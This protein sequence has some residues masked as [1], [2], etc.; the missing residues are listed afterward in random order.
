MR[1]DSRVWARARAM[2]AARWVARLEIWA[3]AGREWNSVLQVETPFALW[4][5]RP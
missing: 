3:Q 2:R 4:L 1:L 5:R